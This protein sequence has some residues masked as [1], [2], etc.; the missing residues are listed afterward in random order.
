M[1]EHAVGDRRVR[2]RVE[3]ELEVH[4]SRKVG[5]AVTVRTCDLGIGGARVISARPLRVDEE[6]EFDFD[7]LAGGPHLHG[8]ARVLRQ[9]RFDTYALRFE[10]IDPGALGR[11]RSFVASSGASAP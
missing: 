6:L 9:Q 4:L 8:T 1:T 3:V 7:L 5:N 10:H 2:Q 11:L